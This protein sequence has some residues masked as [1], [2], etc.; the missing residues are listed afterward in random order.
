MPTAPETRSV[1][2]P[3]GYFDAGTCRSCTWLLLD[4]PT[5]L[6]RKQSAVAAALAAHV[7]PGAWEPPH[8]SRPSGFR[9]KAKLVVGGRRGAVTLGILDGDGLGVD[10]RDCPIHDPVIADAIPR[11]AAAVDELGLTPYDVARR[12]GELKHL[13]LTVSPDGELM[14]RFVLRSEGQLRRLE[15]AVPDIL[16][17][18]PGLRVVT[19]NLQPAHA[20]IL[21]GEQER[22]LTDADH[23]PMRLPSVALRLGPRS[24]FQTN[25]AVAAELYRTATEW[26]TATAPSSLWDLY[27]GVGGFA[28]H[29]AVTPARPARVLGIELSP[30]AI[31]A[32]RATAAG[33]GAEAE[34]RFVAADAATATAEH[35]RPEV[36][37]VNPPRRG[38]G[39]ALTTWIEDVAVPHVVY[40]SCNPRTLAR[41][42]AELPSYRVE[43]AR[44][45][46]MF[47]H[48]AHAEVLVHLART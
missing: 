7:G 45:F 19:A 47:P 35:G 38:I 13:L 43:R 29:A 40:S 22:V 42:L 16:A 24:F 3:C 2:I 6:E 18:V 34:V 33:L 11:L 20:A 36:L 21:E 28:L 9:N 39:T 4:L 15:A 10:L 17:A 48:T 31:E 5:Q 41:D 26:A 12:T 44:L 46:D 27:C 14:A 37:V 23:L 32:A 25:T 1:G 30:E 8:P